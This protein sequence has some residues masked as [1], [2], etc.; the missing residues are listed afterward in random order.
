MAKPMGIV[1]Y[2]NTMNRLYGSEQQV[3]SLP[4]GTS[5]TY[6][7]SEELSPM[8]NIQD[9]I[10]EEGVQVGPQ[11]KDG[12]RIYDTR[13][14]FKPGGLVEPGVTH[15]GTN[16]MTG[17]PA[18][19]A[20]NIKAQKE[21]W[22]K[23]AEAMLKADT[24]GDFEYLMDSPEKVKK[25][26]KQD[27]TRKKIIRHKK[28]MMDGAMR[29]AWRT[30]STNE[31]GLRYIANKYKMDVDRV[32]DI[33]E[34]TKDF[35]DESRILTWREQSLAKSSKIR[36]Q[37]AKGE[38]WMMDNGYRFDDPAKFKSAYI[39]R[40]GRGN[41]FIKAM[42]N[43]TT[44]FFTPK[45]NSEFMG[46]KTTVGSTSKLNKVLGDNIFSSVIY[47]MNPKVKKEILGEFKRALTGDVPT[48]KYQAR[49]ILTQSPLLKKFGL[50]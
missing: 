36:S 43:G 9:L 19:Q 46:Y 6:G 44:S 21:T 27:P 12:G 34:E 8:P 7:A 17:S 13:K 49:K 4:Y 22:N 32:L 41:A 33:M 29:N 5:G 39:K 3:A 2:I 30:L 48:V 20:R 16:P 45:F 37:F 42:K 38:K 25:A 28:G 31:D 35:S 47:N 11:V 1:S 26:L 23:I 10:R 14:Y 18:Q 15:Y 24:T 50:D 40:F